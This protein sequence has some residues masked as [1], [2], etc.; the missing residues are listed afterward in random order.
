[1]KPVSTQWV[2][3]SVSTRTVFVCPPGLAPASKTVTSW[4][5]AR[6]CA[7]ARP[8]IPAPM[9][10]TLMPGALLWRETRGIYRARRSFGSPAPGLGAAVPTPGAGDGRP[11]RAGWGYVFDPSQHAQRQDRTGRTTWLVVRSPTPGRRPSG[12]HL[13]ALSPPQ[14]HRPPALLAR[15][16]GRGRLPLG[17]RARPLRRAPDRGPQLAAVARQGP[18]PDRRPRARRGR[19]RA[20]RRAAHGHRAEA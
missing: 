11:F 16:P 4:V 1:M 5:R 10:A 12:Q 14:P 8:E 6:T 15:Q 7:A 20:R 13:H 19:R 3:C 17:R 18:R 2:S 9:T